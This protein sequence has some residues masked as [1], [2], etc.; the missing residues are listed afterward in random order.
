MEYL[1][2]K[3]WAEEDRPREKLLLKGK[4][5]LTDAEL[6]AIIIGSGTK[7]QSAVELAKHI[8]LDFENDLNALARQNVKELMRFKGI[9]EARAINIVAAF[10]LSRRRS[11]EGVTEDRFIRSSKDIFELYKSQFMDLAHEEFWVVLLNRRNKVLKQ[12]FISSGG[13]AGT[14]VD[15]KIIFKHALSELATSIIL[16]H[17]HPSGN[18]KASH[19]DIRITKKLHQAGELMEV[20]VLDHI[21]FAGNDYYSFADE[22]LI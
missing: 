10:E 1:T 9:G 16:I 4:H 2:I 18:K 3:Q 19:E 17:N 14:V 11:P 7:K 21:I 13:V 12:Q 22:G 20:K 5:I 6:L 15:P 8:L